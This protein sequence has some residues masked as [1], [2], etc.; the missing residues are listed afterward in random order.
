MFRSVRLALSMMT[1]VASMVA[2]AVLPASAQ[3][4]PPEATKLIF[5]NGSSADV[6]VLFSV[7]GNCVVPIAC[8]QDDGCPTGSIK[9]LRTIDLTE[10]GTPVAPTQ[11]GSATRGWF[12]LKRGHRVQFLNTGTNAYTG[13]PSACLQGMIF[14][15]GAGPAIC[16]DSTAATP[17]TTVATRITVPD[18]RPGP[19][20]NNPISI[21]L[22]NGSNGF[23][24]SINLTGTVNGQSTIRN[25]G[26]QYTYVLLPTPHWEQ[27]PANAT[28][29]VGSGTPSTPQ[30]PLVGAPISEAIDLTC[31]NGAN[32]AILV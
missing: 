20:F 11:F 14:G 2:S 24:C 18:T 28:Q 7:P 29:C 19:T 1:L 13:K 3:V 22:P 17:V 31:V 10:G 32:S 27:V 12:L 30:P 4:G 16:P 9:M 21:P 15:F 5:Y 6:T 23:E 8:A 25:P 26:C